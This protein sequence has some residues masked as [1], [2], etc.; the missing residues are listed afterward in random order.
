MRNDLSQN[1]AHGVELKDL[2]FGTGSKTLD[3][4]VTLV[5][6]GPAVVGFDPD[7]ADRNV[8]LPTLAAGLGFFLVNTGTADNLDVIDADSNSVVTLAAGQSA[9]VLGAPTGWVAHRAWAD[10][11]EFTATIDGLVPS[12]GSVDVTKFL[13]SDGAWAVPSGGGGSSAYT[14]ITDG[15]T[16]PITAGTDDT[17]RF[18]S[19]DDSLS[20]SVGTSTTLGDYVDLTANSTSIDHDALLNFVADEHVAHSSVSVGAGYGL[21]GG[22]NLTATSTIGIDFSTLPS[23]FTPT[24]ADSFVFLD[25]TDGG[26]EKI[27]LLSALNSVLDHDALLNFASDEHV[28]HS[29]ISVIAGLGLSGGGTIDGSVT[30][31]LDLTELSTVTVN[32]AEDLVAILD[33]TDNTPKLVIAS[34]LG[35]A[36]GTTATSTSEGIVELATSAEVAAGTDTARVLTPATA[37]AEL[38]FQGK[39]VRQAEW[40]EWLPRETNGPAV[41]IAQ[42]TANTRMYGGLSFD[43][44][45]EESADLLWTPPPSWDGGTLEFRVRYSVAA[46]TGGGVAWGLSG[47]SVGDDDTLDAAPGTEIVV[48][49]TVLAAGD[50][51]ITSWSAAVTITAA[52]AGETVS[53]QLSR[54]VANG[55]D[56]HTTDATLRSVDIRFTIDAKDES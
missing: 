7:G 44:T 24:L 41:S 26:L 30:L 36:G 14:T 40:W 50:I 43:A 32:T 34:S 6:G 20:V 22:G 18:R 39:R 19:S 37:A 13:R 42:S 31:N 17:L 10:L 11:D 15:S 33:A 48:T 38:R 35:G 16:S 51:A 25:V 5:A 56:T 52:A 47:V 2:F 49:D 28:A 1:K 21:T 23:T 54:V 12:P 4:N 27:A 53:L 29:S 3:A 9:W 45:T 55:S 46:S 8:T